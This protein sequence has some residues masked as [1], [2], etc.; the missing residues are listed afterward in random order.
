[1]SVRTDTLQIKIEVDGDG[2][3]RASLAGTEQGLGKIESRAHGANEALQ[4]LKRTGLELVGGFTLAEGIRSMVEMIAESQALEARLRAVASSQ[5]QVNEAQRAAHELA[6]ETAN[7]ADQLTAAYITLAQRGIAPAKDTLLSL[8]NIAAA[9]GKTIDEVADAVGAAMTGQFRALEQLGIRIEQD[10]DKITATFRG[11]KTEI[12]NSSADIIEYLRRIGNSDY[13]GAAAKQAETLTGSWQQLKGAA[14]DLA[15]TVGEQGLTHVFTVL[16]QTLTG[17][18]T[19]I[20]RLIQKAHDS[21]LTDLL[22]A[23]GGIALGGGAFVGASIAN[24]QVTGRQG[25]ALNVQGMA[26]DTIAKARELYGELFA[27]IQKG[28][29]DKASADEKANKEGRD[30][31]DQLQRQLIAVGQGEGAAIRYAAAE[32]AAKVANKDLAAQIIATGNAIA[33]QIDGK[34][35]DQDA[36]K[37]Q[38]EAYADLQQRMSLASGDMKKL[39]DVQADITQAWVDGLISLKQ[40][41]TATDKVADSIDR[42][43]ERQDAEQ[44]RKVN[45]MDQQHEETLGRIVEAYRQ[46]RDELDPVAA[47]TAK[48][49][50]EIETL[51]EAYLKG[52]VDGDKY[53]ET[54]AKILKLMDEARAKGK[55]TDLIGNVTGGNAQESSALL[56]SIMTSAAHTFQEALKKAFRNAGG[57][58]EQLLSNIGD[59]IGQSIIQN[60]IIKPLETYAGGGSLD[61]TSLLQGGSFALGVAGGSALGGGGNRAGQGAEIGAIAG[62]VVGSIFPVIGTYIGSIVG[63][64]LGGFIGGMFEK[65]PK[66]KIFNSAGGSNIDAYGVDPFG[67]ANIYTY[68]MGDGAAQQLLQAVTQLDK[69]IASLLTADQIKAVQGAL[70]NQVAEGSTPDEALAAR[71]NMIIAAVEPQWVAFLNKFTDAQSKASAFASLLNLNKQLLNFGQILDSIS[72]NP[73]TQLNAQL[74]SLDQQVQTTANALDAAITSQDPTQIEQASSA[75]IQAVVNRYQTEI[76]LAQTLEQALAAAKQQAYQLNLSIAQHIAGITGDY[77]GVQSVAQGRINEL[78]GQIPNEAP[79]QGLGD[80]ND[81]I[82]S[83]DQ[84]LAAG[85][86]GINDWLNSSLQALQAEA[87]ARQAAAQRAAQAAEARRQRELQALQQQLQLAQQWVDVLNHAKQLQD[88]MAFGT[89]NPL[90]TFGQLDALNTAIANLVHAGASGGTGLSS[91]LGA[92]GTDLSNLSSDQANQLLDLLQQRLQLLQ[93]GLSQ[94]PTQD[95][96]NQYNQTLA[97]IQQVQALAQP[98]VDQSIALQQQIADLQSQTISA[99]NTGT[100]GIAAQERALRAEAQERLDALNQQALGYYTWAQGQAQGME[101]ARTQELLA[102]LNQLTGGLPVQDFIALKQAEANDLLTQIRDDIRAF[103]E[104]IGGV[105]YSGSGSGSGNGGGD[106]IGTVGPGGSRGGSNGGH[107][108]HGNPHPPG[109]GRSAVGDVHVVVNI[110]GAGMSR[111]EVVRTFH[112][113]VRTAAASIKR[114]LAVA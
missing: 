73:V 57:D 70:N 1:M 19:A 15:T 81:F 95:Y 27:V 82:G 71:L 45:E 40:Y 48:Y 111:D 50:D 79:G 91:G 16:T 102:E 3:V 12:G 4:E 90:G 25:A 114:T 69:V 18:V 67:R 99:V 10:G 46:L 36:A 85:Q 87:Q 89:S 38:A 30:T 33:A 21:S 20:D 64:L 60:K 11:T 109:G 14:S 23:A 66:A 2:N 105:D 113:E 44:M 80:L 13:A 100:A 31:L 97:L 6:Q 74:E 106:G 47:A 43:R 78:Q 83:V 84:W 9:S 26:L 63:G 55:L 94:R 76:Q 75:A 65:D 93:G 49:Q 110:N 42:L 39:H 108:G 107:S 92:H 7:S 88:S 17:S 62:A 61:T 96:L 28:M 41:Q 22:K 56:D 35:A 32:A 72:G 103:L 58:F 34:K 53:A 8:S 51:N 86:Q 24:E 37:A 54:L 29:A 68:G 77:S 52:L 5:E 59:Q 98:H 112:Q 104:S 101:D